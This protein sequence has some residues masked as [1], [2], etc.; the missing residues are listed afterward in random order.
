[1]SRDG[2]HPD[3]LRFAARAYERDDRLSQLTPGP[4]RRDL[5][6]TEALTTC[7]AVLA[8]MTARHGTPS[9]QQ[10]LLDDSWCRSARPPGDRATGR[11]GD[12]ATALSPSA[13]ATVEAGTCRCWTWR[14]GR[15]GGTERRRARTPPFMAMCQDVASF[16][17]S[18]PMDI[19]HCLLPS[20]LVLLAGCS[21]PQPPETERRP[22]PQ[23]A[24]M[25]EA[26]AQPLADAKAATA[27][28]E[29]AAKAEQKAMQAADAAP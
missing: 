12:R 8:V 25:R 11:Q 7:D 2:L 3:G 13:M 1:M 22:D 28:T 17:R 26:I 9:R 24:A 4:V 18:V 14:S 20:T 29:E 21:N 16:H 10:D 6:P 19:R 23:A 15:Y 27:A 5:P